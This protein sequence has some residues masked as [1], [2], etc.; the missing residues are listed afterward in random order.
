MKPGRIG[1]PSY[2]LPLSLASASGG[3][4]RCSAL[5]GD[6]LSGVDLL[7]WQPS[8]QATVVRRWAAQ[9]AQGLLDVGNLEDANDLAVAAAGAAVGIVDVDV[10]SGQLLAHAGQGAG[11]IAEF[12]HQDVRL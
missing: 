5:P 11:L 4:G 10:F 3:W 2:T 8:L 1:N 6:L 12:D 7:A 9:H